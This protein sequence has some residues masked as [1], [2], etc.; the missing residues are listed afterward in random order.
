MEGTTSIGITRSEFSTLANSVK[1]KIILPAYPEV[2]SY[3]APTTST[4][5]TLIIGDVLAVCASKLK[6]FSEVGYAKIHPGGKLGL[7]L[8]KISSIMRKDFVRLPAT[9]PLLE[10]LPQMQAGFA[11]IENGTILTDGDIRRVLLSQ[12][13]NI[14]GVLL[15]DVGT[16]NPFILHED[17]AVIKAIEVFNEKKIGT[18]LVKNNSEAVV[19]VVDRKDIEF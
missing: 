9:I 19:G 4:T 1:H 18:I 16:K 5:Q 8:Q 6:G 15:G 14:N 7:S 11:Y 12:K 13:G 2:V 17:E 3:N 10:A